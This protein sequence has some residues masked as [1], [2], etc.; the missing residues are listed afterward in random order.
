MIRH[1]RAATSAVAGSNIS[2]SPRC[3]CW[4]LIHG[5]TFVLASLALG[6]LG[7]HANAEM[8][9]TWV[10]SEEVTYE[11]DWYWNRANGLTGLSHSRTAPRV[12]LR[13]EESVLPSSNPVLVQ[14]QSTTGDSG[15]PTVPQTSNIPPPATQAAEPG[16]RDGDDVQF[17]PLPF[18]DDLK[19]QEIEQQKPEYPTIPDFAKALIPNYAWRRHAHVYTGPTDN[20]P[21]QP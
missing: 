21:L 18:P 1:L 16:Y 9:D 5:L 8:F 2:S 15:L 7:D 6:M 14:P 13:N 11:S 3:A 12:A 17:E 19:K 4:K 10:D 20:T